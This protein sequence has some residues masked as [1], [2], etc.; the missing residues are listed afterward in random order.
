MALQKTPNKENEMSRFT[1]I[2]P[3]PSDFKRI[4]LILLGAIIFSLNL[5][6]FVYA[7]EIF[8]GGFSGISLLVQRSAEK[9]F[10]IKIPYTVLYLSL[11][12]APGVISFLFIGKKFTLFSLLMIALSSVLTDALPQIQLTNDPLLCSV[13]GGILNGIAVTCCLRAD[14]TSGGTDFI[15]IY[16]S[17]KRGVDMWNYIF[18]MNVC[19]LIV[20]G[21]IFGWDKALY[22]IVFQFSSTQVLNRLYRHYQKITMLIVT[23]KPDDLYKI[24]KQVT[25]HD[26]TRFV[27]TG[28]FRNSQKTLLYT[29][30]S[31]D[32]LG[33][34]S[35]ALKSCDA[36]AFINVLQTKEIF[37]RFFTKTKD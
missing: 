21:F 11:N 15:A 33:M 28:C 1:T 5:N 16:F 12:A 10:D 23:E 24:I 30:V 6:S 9:F 4:L 27:G 34:L 37:G 31:A 25:N 13:F 14:A 32:E 22:S 17:E 20:A 8:P 35:K 19:V 29:V 18:G 36:E 7:A 3:T 26:A 2:I